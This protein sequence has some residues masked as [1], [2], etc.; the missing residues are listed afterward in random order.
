[1][2]ASF[3]MPR[4][5]FRQRRWPFVPLTWP[6]LLS[7][8]FFVPSRHR[9]L[10]HF[11]GLSTSALPTGQYHDLAQTPT[12]LTRALREKKAQAR[13]FFPFM[14]I[15]VHAREAKHRGTL[16]SGTGKKPRFASWNINWGSIVLLPLMRIRQSVPSTDSSHIG[17]SC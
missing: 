6:A 15:H 2:L 17:L 8:I 13:S 9:D 5:Y 11:T 7:K 1:M 10:S 3:F 4:P 12:M 16:P 14:C